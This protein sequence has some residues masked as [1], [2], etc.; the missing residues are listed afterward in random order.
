MITASDTK[1][2]HAHQFESAEQQYSSAKQGIWLFLCTEMLMF[3]GLFVAYTIYMQ[4]YPEVFHRGS[5]MLNVTL[6]AFNT[7]MLL[8][9]SFT[10]TL[11]I[12]YIQKDKRQVATLFLLSTLFLA[13]A[14]LVVKYFEYSH[15][16]HDGL[17][18]GKYFTNESLKDLPNAPLYFGFYFVMTGLH[19]FHILVGIG[20]ILWVTIKNLLGQMGSEYFTPVESVGLYWHVVDLVWI[21]LFPLL[22]LIG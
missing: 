6:G 12:H 17:L 21:F 19:G 4:I 2:H 11:A 1:F 13:C 10:M 8:T 18:P 14:F 15:K 3:G 5:Q 9:S 16:I 7:L 22:Y 20:L